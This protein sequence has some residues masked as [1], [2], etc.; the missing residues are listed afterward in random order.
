M[1]KI[2][3]IENYGGDGIVQFSADAVKQMTELNAIMRTTSGAD[4]I[5][6]FDT[7]KVG[8]IKRLDAIN[9]E[10]RFKSD[11][12]V[13][14]VDDGIPHPDAI[15][16]LEKL[17]KYEI[18]DDL[19]EFNVLHMYPRRYVEGEGYVDSQFFDVHLYNWD[20]KPWKKRIIRNRDGLKFS[21]SVVTDIVRI[22]ADGSTLIRFKPAA[23]IDG[24]FQC[25]EIF[26]I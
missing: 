6:A 11:A 10:P 2:L 20:T 13:V 15:P 14:M 18:D 4:I 3:L 7:M 8:E 23:S 24:I 17:N 25:L 26:G 16:Y 5:E 19:T 12:V 21:Q 22:Y 9:K 1:R